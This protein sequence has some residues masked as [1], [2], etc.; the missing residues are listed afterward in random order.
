M[1]YE[2]RLHIGQSFPNPEGTASYLLTVAMIDL[3]KAGSSTH[4]GTVLAE[5]REQDAG[6]TYYWYEDGDNVK[7]TTDSYGEALRQVP[8]DA[9]TR[10]LAADIHDAVA[11]GGHPYRRF[12]AAHSLLVALSP[13]RYGE[14][15]VVVQYGY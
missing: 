14:P 4:T 1:G 3:S 9:L 10:A 8:W 6:L 7:I 11:N 15:L 12:I 2:T 13:E 5:A